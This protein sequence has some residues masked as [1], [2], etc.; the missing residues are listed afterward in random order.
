MTV[1]NFCAPADQATTPVLVQVVGSPGLQAHK[2]QL[3]TFP[4]SDSKEPAP[5]PVS[6]KPPAKFQDKARAADEPKPELITCRLTLASA[7]AAP[8]LFQRAAKKPGSLPAATLPAVVLER[9]FTKLS[10]LLL[11]LTKLPASLRCRKDDAKLLDGLAL[12]AGCF[13]APHGANTSSVQWL[14]RPSELQNPDYFAQAQQAIVKHGGGAYLAYRPGGRANLG[15]RTSTDAAAPVDGGISPRWSLTGAP[16][17]WMPEDALQWLVAHGFSKVTQVG[18]ASSNAWYFRVWPDAE[19]G[20]AVYESGICVCCCCCRPEKWQKHKSCTCRRSAPQWGSSAAAAVAKLASKPTPSSVGEPSP[21]TTDAGG[22]EIMEG[23]PELDSSGA[24]AEKRAYS[25][26]AVTLLPGQAHFEDTECGGNGD[27]AYL[28]IAAAMTAFSKSTPKFRDLE[29]KGRLQGYL[30]CQAANQLRSHPAKYS[31]ACPK[32]VDDFAKSTSTAG[33]WANA[34]SLHALAC[35]LRCQFRVWTWSPQLSKW[36]LYIVGP[37]RT[38]KQKGCSNPAVIWLRLYNRHYTWLKPKG[39]DWDLDR[40]VPKQAVRPTPPVFVLLLPS[41]VFGPERNCPRNPLSRTLRTSLTVRATSTP[42]LVVGSLPSLRHPLLL[43]GALSLTGPTGSSLLV[44][45]RVALTTMLE[46]S[47]RRSRALQ[48]YSKFVAGLKA[49]KWKASACVPAEHVPTSVSS[50]AAEGPRLSTRYP[51]ERCG[52]TATL[53]EFRRSPCKLRP[54]SVSV[55][56]W[57]LKTRGRE[58]ADAD[59]SRIQSKLAKYF[60]SAAGRAARQRNA[61]RRRLKQAQS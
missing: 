47:A 42:A 15:V 48:S 51:C 55:Y 35:S 58:A 52:R 25:P 10:L 7:Y 30:R 23:K 50:E 26:E 43:R 59:W 49:Q 27:C 36:L 44:R 28:T 34:V 53:A 45:R 37:P 8:Y 40:L 4:G 14:A 12:P 19:A 18:R 33:V 60:T 61:E 24:N 41:W 21:A 2:V 38:K 39:S 54:G 32:G 11:T 16:E 6:L 46:A 57:T 22:D 9:V 20:T 29:A 1:A 17:E 31:D 5:Q 3:R 13:V 56:D